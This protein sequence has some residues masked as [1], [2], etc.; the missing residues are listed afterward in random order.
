[1]YLNLLILFIT[2]FGAGMAVFLIPDLNKKKFKAILSFSGA[3]LF[4]IT[5]IH[6]LPELF[7]ESTAPIQAGM[8][9]L[10]GFFLQMMLEYF[11][12]GVEHGH[13][14]HH[15]ET[16]AIPFM[17]LVSLGIHSFLEGTLLV[18]PSSVHGNEGAGT[19]MFG[20][21]MHKIPEAFALMSVLV[22]QMK[23][24]S[25]AIV[26]MLLFALTS[27]LGMLMSNALYN[28][29]L[30]TKDIFGILFALV[31]GNFLHISTTI[32]FESSP[33]HKFKARKLL[34]SASGAGMAILAE[35]FMGH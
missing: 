3:Y 10:L 4:S 15:H 27:P 31:A 17:L 16:S 2:A 22:L 24:K 30:I 28:W 34:L 12:E 25:L 8:F 14:H 32:F 13:I 1:M 9:V 35:Y 21:I 33:D 6:I 11:S 20:L 19:L 29:N 23:N 5:V 26:M 18:H 7:H